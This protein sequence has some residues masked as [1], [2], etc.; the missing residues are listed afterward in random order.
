MNHRAPSLTGVV[1]S[2][3]VKGAADM[4]W[5]T[6]S[7]V[8]V[9]LFEGSVNSMNGGCSGQVLQYSKHDIKGGAKK[10]EKEVG[11]ADKIHL[12]RLQPRAL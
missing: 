10:K 5:T 7:H 2:T 6:L 1:I 4:P 11:G 8:V 12:S 3:C 9:E